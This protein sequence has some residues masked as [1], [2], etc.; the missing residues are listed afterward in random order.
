MIILWTGIHV[1]CQVIDSNEKINTPDESSYDS[2][3]SS[4]GPEKTQ[5]DNDYEKFM[6]SRSNEVAAPIQRMS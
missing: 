2:G 6:A 5:L 4:S 1:Q 3:K